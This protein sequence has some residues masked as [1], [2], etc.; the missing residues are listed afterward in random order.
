MELE[1]MNMQPNIPDSISE[2]YEKLS[3]IPN[4]EYETILER[5]Y[6]SILGQGDTAVDIGAHVGRHTIPMSDCVGDIGIIFA[7]EPLPHLYSKL[8][9]TLITT[10]KKNIRLFNLALSRETGEADFIHVEDA[11]GLSGLMH[12]TSQDGHI[13]NKIRVKLEMLDNVVTTHRPVKFIKIDAEGADFFILQGARNI[14]AKDRPV[15]VFESGK[16]KSLPAK[17][18]GYSQSD[19]I[20]F[21]DELK[22]SIY[23]IGGFKFDHKYWERPTLNDFIALPTEF[24]SEYR[25]TLLSSVLLQFIQAK[26]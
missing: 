17:S 16:M 24:E 12:R 11:P 1:L 22:Y 20:R 10:E 23:D 15:V 26:K 8:V 3:L 4:D 19:F 18:Y 13:V 2:C 5:F 7:F 9:N 6:R 25:E 21:F 14:L